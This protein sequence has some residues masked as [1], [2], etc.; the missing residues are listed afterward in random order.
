MEYAQSVFGYIIG[1]GFVPQLLLVLLVMLIAYAIIS[2]FEV[3]VD[4]FKRYGRLTAVLAPN[5]YT[6]NLVVPQDPNNDKVPLIYPSENE[7]DG[8][9]FSYSFHL[10]ISPETFE[11]TYKPETCGASATSHNVTS[12]RHVLVKGS[13]NAFP[14][15][16]PGIFVHGDKNVL[17]VY[18]NSTSAWDNY[19]DIPN[20]PVGKWFHFVITMKGRFLDAYINGNVIAR[21]EFRTVPKL[22]YLP[23]YS[24]YP[25]AKNEYKGRDKKDDTE[26]VYKVDGPMKGMISRLKYYAF[27]LNYSQIDSLYREGP[28]RVIESP[29]FL[30]Q[31]PYNHD[32][33]WVTKY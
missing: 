20:I 22:N 21:H 32:S 1:P 15:M 26:V 18:M 28:S 2:I 11:S 9:E 4:V 31:P 24:M 30:Q 12:L 23:V 14:V 8:M 33:W 5:T 13:R 29:S 16:A 7:T 27:A 3:I 10:F 6:G 19:V 25:M 17:R